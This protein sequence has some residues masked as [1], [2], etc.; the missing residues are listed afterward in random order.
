MYLRELVRKVELDTREVYWAF[1][2]LQYVQEACKNVHN[3]L[4][5][6]NGENKLQD[7]RYFIP[8]KAPSPMTTDCW[9]ETDV[10]PELNAV[11][12][13]YYQSLI[14]VMSWMVELGRVD[15]C[16]EVLMLS[17]CLALPRE[18]THATIVSYVLIP[19]EAT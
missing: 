12:A 3:H 15:I 13:A 16:T 1:S 5:L 4:K 18:G 11:D 19:G 14:G 17:S 8:K 2:S 9:A 10:S 7:C 6:R